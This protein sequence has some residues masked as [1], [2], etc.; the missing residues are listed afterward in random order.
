MYICELTTQEQKE[1]ALKVKKALEELGEYTEKNFEMA[2]NSKLSDLEE[3][4]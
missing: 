2:M 1:I 3:L 4:F